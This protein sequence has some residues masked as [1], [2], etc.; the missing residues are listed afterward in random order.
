MIGA[1]CDDGQCVARQC[2]AA[3]DGTSGDACATDAD[4]AAGLRCGLLG[5]GLTCTAE[6]DGD[7][8]ASCATGTDCLA[9][10]ACLAQKCAVSPTGTPA[11]GTPWKGVACEK[12]VN[13]GVKAYFEVPAAPGADQGDFFRLPFPNDV[14]R[15]SGSLNLSGFPTPG[16]GSS[17]VD[18]VQ[19][20]V[21]AISEHD[22]GWGAYPTVIFRFSGEFDYATFP[23]RAVQFFDVTTPVKPRAMGW[24][25]FFTTGRTNYVC[26][27]FVAVQP[28]RGDPLQPG[29]TYAVLILAQAPDE[30][31]QLVTLVGAGDKQPVARSAHFDIV[32]TGAVPTDPELQPGRAAF[33]RLRGFLNS[34]TGEGASFMT[35]DNVLT[36]S[37][38]TVGEVRTPMVELAEAVAKTRVPSARR[39]VKCG[40]SAVSPCPQADDERACGDDVDGFD[41]YQALLSLPV[42]QRGTP[43]YLTPEDGGD[44]DLGAPHFEEVC[45]S[46]TV[47]EGTPPSAGWPAVVFAHGTGGSFRDHV[48]DEVAGALA[49]AEPKFAVVGIDQVQ[50]G[51]RRGASQEA[52][53]NLFFNF[54]NPAASRGNP[55]Q[56]AA[57]QL[58]LARF[59]KAL[60][61]D[62]ATSTGAAIKL[63]GSRL[64]FFGHSQ[65]ATEGSL[66]LPFGDDYRAAVLSGNGASLRDAL[67]TKTKPRNVAA[68]LPLVLQEA[69]AASTPDLMSV[70][71]VLS[72][73]Q[74]W[75]DPAD[76]LNFGQV[77][78]T[79]LV[80]HV[81]KH[82]FQTFGIGD[83]YSPP[84]TLETFALAAQLTQVTP[85]ESADPVYVGSLPQKAIEPPGFQAAPGRFTL[86]MR[87][88][89]AP[90]GRD[91][92]FVVFDTRAAND[93]VLLFLTGAAGDEPP[94]IGQ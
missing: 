84:E 27:N 37:V 11:V 89:G 44:I 17:G 24:Q 57:D 70:H 46:L 88:Y 53:D 55:L 15:Q 10:L 22:S 58:S 34:Y 83:S 71:P 76:P 69:P 6:G 86:G 80:G 61:I 42:F 91:G 3:G 54:S 35:A 93:D 39:W 2:V 81:G 19:L 94:V 18:A 90:R 12:P 9:G 32:M 59:V 78:A 5:L 85:H 16:P 64:L 75:I 36:A 38:F 23:N 31:E 20:Y 92:H 82:V 28:P 14:R 4:C 30:Q 67:Y 60:D 74:Q 33:G 52:P 48:R 66:M 43:P 21:D 72:L 7:L 29:H 41:E 49:A 50:H 77:I 45:L 47:P 73:L 63:D 26:E 62:A 56:G 79:P 25:R 51:P 1:E 68:A 40:G 13:T 65:G 8:G 87:Q